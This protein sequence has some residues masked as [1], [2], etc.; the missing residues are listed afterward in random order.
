MVEELKTGKSQDEIKSLKREN[1]FLEINNLDFYDFYE[2]GHV[3]GEVFIFI[4]KF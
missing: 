4:L 2:E 1:S 3:L